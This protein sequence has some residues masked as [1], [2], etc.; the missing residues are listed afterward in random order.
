MNALDPMEI[1]NKKQLIV[2]IF[3]TFFA[4]KYTHIR[5][6]LENRW[7]GAR[8]KFNN[9]R[10]IFNLTYSMRQAI[11]PYGEFYLEFSEHGVKSTIH[12]NFDFRHGEKY[13]K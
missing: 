8:E 2:Y 10:G 5:V 1:L 4:G 11:L 6:S 3:N 13:G 12:G 9:E 7:H